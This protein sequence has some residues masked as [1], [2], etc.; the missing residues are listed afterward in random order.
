[1]TDNS[2]SDS[3]SFHPVLNGSEAT[4]AEAESEEKETLLIVV[5]PTPLPIPI[6]DLHWMVT[7]LALPITTPRPSPSLV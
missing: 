7:F 5:T 1:M 6:F 4:E 3:D 2:A